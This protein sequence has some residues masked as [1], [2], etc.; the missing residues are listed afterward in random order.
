MSTVVEKKKRGR[1]PKVLDQSITD[2][3]NSKTTDT[4]FPIE[5]P[6]IPQIINLSKIIENNEDSYFEENF[7]E[8]KP[9]IMTPNAYKK[10]D[11]FLS[12]PF[13]VNN[14]IIDN[15]S[16]LTA[17]HHEWPTQTDVYCL[18]CCHP[19][20]N[21][22]IGIPVKI[23]KKRFYC[24]GIFCSF[25]C[26]ASHN[27]ECTDINTNVWERFNLLNLMALKNNI[28]LPI[29]CAKP[30]SCLKIFGGNLDITDFRKF[31]K[32]VIYFKNTFPMVPL[33]E[34]IEELCDSFNT[35]N[36]ELFTI[37]KDTK[38]KQTSINEFY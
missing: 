20:T 18:W 9:D 35:N 7:C 23:S 4:D 1:K 2:A 12:I 36:N 3:I 16:V 30:K 33:C 11:N 25:E 32:N 28:N 6:E 37:R 27:Y 38:N 31:S 13:H 19:F 14:E 8:Y 5:E 15:D 24:I 34:Q 22:P 21:T 17:D 10:E 26:A 29:R